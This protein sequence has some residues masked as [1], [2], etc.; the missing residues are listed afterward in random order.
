M[1]TFTKLFFVV[2][3]IVSGLIFMSQVIRK[4]AGHGW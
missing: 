3:F 4:D 2:P 1:D